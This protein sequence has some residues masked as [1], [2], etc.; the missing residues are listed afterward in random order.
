LEGVQSRLNN[1]GYH[2]GNE[3]GKN[4][5]STKAAV[6]AFKQKHRLADNDIVDQAMKDKL[7]SEYGL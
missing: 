2:C 7:L 6:R 4:D 1:L 5:K 3:E